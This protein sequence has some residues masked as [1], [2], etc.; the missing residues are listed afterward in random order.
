MATTALPS[1]QRQGLFRGRKEKGNAKYTKSNS[2][3]AISR[4][5]SISQNR[6]KARSRSVGPVTTNRH[7]NGS[8]GYAVLAPSASSPIST[9]CEEGPC[10]QCG[11]H[12]RRFDITQKS[13]AAMRSIQELYDELS[14]KQTNS[15]SCMDWQP[16][17]TTYIVREKLAAGTETLTSTSS[18]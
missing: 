3:R 7:R 5:R 2:G 17:T 10:Y 4:N 13:W 12:C 15:Q 1:A 16:S 8:V 14:N 18:P 11:C 6:D 9:A